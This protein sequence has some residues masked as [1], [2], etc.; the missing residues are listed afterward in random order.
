MQRVVFAVLSL[1]VVLTAGATET[2]S[3]GLY[4][5]T[6]ETTMKMGNMEM[7]PRASRNEQC[8]TAE[9][10][11]KGPPVP[12]PEDGRTD[13]DLRSYEFGDGKIAMEMACTM[14]G[15]EGVMVGT[16]SYTHD[17]FDM[18]NNFKMDAQGMQMEM[19]VTIKSERVGDC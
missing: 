9:D 1:S 10:A 12:M 13:C 18:V 19:S 8:I 15:G 3:P 5:S 4:R 2:I 7:P 16:G 17:S 11:A 6:A 14:P